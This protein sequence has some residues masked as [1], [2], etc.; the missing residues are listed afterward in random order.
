MEL[1]SPHYAH[2]VNPCKEISGLVLCQNLIFGCATIRAPAMGVLFCPTFH[3]LRTSERATRR[4]RLA[5]I[6]SIN[7][8]LARLFHPFRR[9]AP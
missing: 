6:L 9:E 2:L 8:A 4:R 5:P 1:L 3:A 7:K